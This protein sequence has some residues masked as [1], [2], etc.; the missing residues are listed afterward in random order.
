MKRRD[1]VVGLILANT[2][3]HARAERAGKVYRLA[4]VSPATPPAEM[5]ETNPN[6]Y[7]AQG[8][9]GFFE[10]LRRLGYVEGQNLIVERYSGEG[11]PEHFRTLADN[12]VRRN[13]DVV[14]AIGA[15]L[16]LAF[17]AATT[18][19]PVVA[20]TADPVALGI[21]PS[22]ARPGGNITGAS[23]DG[24][25]E[26][27]D[28]RLDLLREAFPKLSRLGLLIAH[29]ASGIRAEALL[30]ESSQSRGVSLVV[31]PLGAPI[32]ETAY[33]HAFAAMVES[34]A[35][36]VYV[37]QDAENDAY[38]QVIV[39]LAEKYRLPAIYGSRASAAI[40]GLMAY[41]YDL[42]DLVRHNADQ[43]DQ[44]FK[45]AKPGDIPYYQ[46]RQFDLIINLKTAKILGLTIAPSLLAQANEVIE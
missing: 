28:K 14:Y 10:E 40:G 33:R 7:L 2:V 21:V 8:Y 38:G 20:L 42:L 26:V 4:I 22:L 3:R 16:T 23:L 39:D 36:A 11:H 27:W 41:V 43:M 18:P 6:R 19:V 44:I 30:K 46:T 13:P 37:G 17:K 35:D 9:R 29:D 24:G 31:S 12:V 45:G 1:F 15:P 34:G 5:N 25:I 32:G